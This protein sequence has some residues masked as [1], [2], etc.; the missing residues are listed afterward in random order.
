MIF[1]PT[2]AKISSRAFSPLAQQKALQKCC[3]PALSSIQMPEAK[4]SQKSA[5]FFKA[6]KVMHASPIEMAGKY[7]GAGCA[8]IGCAG[9]GVGIGA[10][11][12][13]LCMAVARNPS[14]KGQLFS[15]A[16]LGFAMAE[17][18]GLFSLMM[19]FLILIV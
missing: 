18:M 8:T 12:G 7:V 1:V 4:R 15:Y 2:I 5:N 16:I 6:N 17:A 11:F 19:A 10:I 9:A 14:Q 13:S 3:L